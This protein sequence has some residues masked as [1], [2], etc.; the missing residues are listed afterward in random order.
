M[1][2]EENEIWLKKAV[3]LDR[4]TQLTSIQNRFF[5][6]IA[7]KKLANDAIPVIVANR[8]MVNEVSNIE[9]KNLLSNQL[10][11]DNVQVTILE[12]EPEGLYVNKAWTGIVILNIKDKKISKL[13]KSYKP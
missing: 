13:L 5:R 7:F 2:V 6:R 8:V 4:E 10:T 12:K 3:L 1:T 9:L 11:T